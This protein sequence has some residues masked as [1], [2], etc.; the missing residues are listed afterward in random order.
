MPD[1][2]H[3][4][5]EPRHDPYFVETVADLLIFNAGERLNLTELTGADSQVVGEAVKLLRRLGFVIEAQQ[6]RAGYTL[7]GWSRAAWVHVG[8]LAREYAGVMARTCDRR[9]R[10]VQCPGQLELVA[11]SVAE[12]TSAATKGSTKTSDSRPFVRLSS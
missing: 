12:C 7:E 9:R 11:D 4:L 8:K 3:R 6:G 1:L 10:V 5:A 2:S